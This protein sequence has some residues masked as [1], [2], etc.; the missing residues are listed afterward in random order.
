MKE[1]VDQSISKN[2]IRVPEEKDL[3]RKQKQLTELI[4]EIEELEKREEYQKE[5]MWI[6]LIED[7]FSRLKEIE[8]KRMFVPV[9]DTIAHAEIV[10]QWNERFLVTQERVNCVNRKMMKLAKAESMKE[11][12][13]KW[14]QML[15]KGASK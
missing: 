12:I 4:N 6:C 2:P 13:A 10:G 15:M 5:P 7:S 1:I 11:R 14:I 8:R 3:I 9:T